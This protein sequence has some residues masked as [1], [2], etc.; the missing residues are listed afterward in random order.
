[1]AWLDSLTIV[2]KSFEFLI[3][4]W[5]LI[6]NMLNCVSIYNRDIIFE[7]MILCVIFSN[8]DRKS[9]MESIECS[10]EVFYDI[11]KRDKY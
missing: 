2:I 5:L 1:M 10:F 9:I 8:T 3:K 6:Q 4:E 11:Y 7:P